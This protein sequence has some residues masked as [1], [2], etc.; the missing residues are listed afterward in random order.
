MPRA[1][2]L[3][4]H[5]AR[6]ARVVQTIENDVGAPL[7]LDALAKRA[8][9]A[10]HHFHRVFRGIVG[11]SI[12]EHTRRLRLERAARALGRN[13]GGRRVTEI[14]FDAGYDS[15]EAFTHAFV[16]L[17]GVPPSAWQG[18]EDGRRAGGDAPPPV[19]VVRA[20]PAIHAIGERHLGSYATVGKAFGRVVARGLAVGRAGPLLGLCP[21][22][23]DVTPEDR[24]RFDACLA[25]E[26]NDDLGPT[27]LI[28][29]GTY[30]VA[31]HRGPYTTLAETYLALIGRWLPSTRHELC[32]EPVVEAYLND[33][34]VCG[35]DALLTEVRVRLAD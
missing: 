31:I 34:T 6:I 21:D 5:R 23:P 4:D 1:S 29:A 19:V 13:N 12:V 17:F 9:Y 2:T 32:D 3:E 14:A 27:L 22:D 18:R 28:P 26:P 30:A 11:E 24:L 15:P 25:T 10:K 16:R 35:A 8:A 20:L 7:D 33:P